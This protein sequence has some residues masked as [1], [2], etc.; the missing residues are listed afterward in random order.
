M[1]WVQGE[2]MRL[3]VLA[4]TSEAR[5]ISMALARQRV[6][7]VVVA[8]ARPDPSP[9]P[10]GVP[11]R[12]G[13]FEGA[14]GLR[15][16]VERD[17]ITAI[18]DAM[19]PFAA[20][21]TT[22]CAQVA[23]DTETD[24]IQFLRPAWRPEPG[25]RWTFINSLNDVAGHIP[26]DANVMVTT[27][28]RTMDQLSGLTSQTVFVRDASARQGHFP[29]AKGRFVPSILQASIDDE[30]DLLERL[31]VDWVVAR[32]SGGT[33]GRAM[34]DAARFLNIPVAMLRRPLQPEVPRVDTI[35]AVLSWVRNRM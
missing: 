20:E 18:V 6:T 7:R 8:L 28:T 11:V 14:D 10:Y 21:F 23:D 12:I 35:S 16:F 25:D 4:G 26:M 13:E 22:V 24:Y 33:D 29:F 3:L 34:I 19:T 32:N 31:N 30:I 17:R 15:D 5:Q 1:G 27:G 2:T 9:K